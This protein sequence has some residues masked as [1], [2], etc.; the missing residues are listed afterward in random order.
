MEFLF[1]CTL[2]ENKLEVVSNPF[3][4]GVF[5]DC[6]NT[7]HYKPKQIDDQKWWLFQNSSKDVANVVK[8]TIEDSEFMWRPRNCHFKK[9]EI[10]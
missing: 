2:P 10:Y 4:I 1:K 3:S 7:T 9:C 5:P 8:T 6:G